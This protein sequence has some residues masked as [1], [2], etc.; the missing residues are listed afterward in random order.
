MRPTLNRTRYSLPAFGREATLKSR[1]G[2]AEIFAGFGGINSWRA[3]NTGLETGPLSFRRDSSFN[4]AWLVQS[5]VGT[6]IAVLRGKHVWFGATYR[7]VENFGT[8]GPRRWNSIGGNVT[9]VF[10]R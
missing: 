6:R 2:R 5:W 7:H 3:D 8:D 1:S 9:F 4:D 10:G